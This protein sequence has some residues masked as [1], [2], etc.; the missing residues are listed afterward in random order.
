M[1]NPN[2][3]ATTW[4]A[5]A[6]AADSGHL[7]LD[8][9][10]AQSCHSAC[11]AYIS[12]LKSHQETARALA[13]VTGFGDFQMGDQ[14]RQIFAD[15]AVGGENNMVDVLQSHIDVVEKMK[16]VFGKFFAATNAVDDSN[17]AGLRAEGPN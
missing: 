6:V 15:K 9:G 10:A 5:L 17:A 13:D 2:E 4:Q 7:Y 11:D 16:V 3:P 1:G 8:P 12:K 14:L